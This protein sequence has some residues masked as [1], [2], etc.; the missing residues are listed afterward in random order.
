MTAVTVSVGMRFRHPTDTVDVTIG[1]LVFRLD[2]D[3][4]EQAMVLA[5]RTAAV[6]GI[7]LAPS[8]PAINPLDDRSVPGFVV[9]QRVRYINPGDR[10][11]QCAGSIIKIA[12]GWCAVNIDRNDGNTTE[13]RAGVLMLVPL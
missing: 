8:A 9:G 12:A 2:A 4:K 7:G 5:S 1:G 11:D 6:L 13:K 3:N 10:Y